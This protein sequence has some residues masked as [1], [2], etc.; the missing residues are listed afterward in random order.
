MEAGMKSA[1]RWDADFRSGRLDFLRRPSEQM[2]LGEIA[3]MV[4]R[5][6]RLH[7]PVEVVDLGCGEGLLLGRL[8]PALVKRYVAVDISG[9]A[10]KAIREGRVPVARVRASV[11]AWDGRPE[12]VAP[13]IIVASE[14]LYYDPQG[15]THV[16]KAAAAMPRTVEVIVSCVQGRPDKPNW[17]ASSQRLWRDM[18]L[19]GWRRVEAV[20]TRDERAGLAW[21]IARYAL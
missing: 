17:T 15:V 3:A 18:R 21:D 8:D 1:A 10:L 20:T 4:G 19:T 7:G 11:A 12:P 16:R 14:V 2:R 6:A 13:R 5:A 9:V